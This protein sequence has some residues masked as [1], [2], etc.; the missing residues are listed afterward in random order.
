LPTPAGLDLSDPLP[1]G[2]PRL[3][4]A[5]SL[6]EILFD[7]ALHRIQQWLT[8]FHEDLLQV[9]QGGVRQFNRVLVIGQNDFRPQARGIIWD[10]RAFLASGGT[11]PM[12]PM[13]NYL[14]DGQI[15]W[16][17]FE[18]HLPADYPDQGLVS[19]M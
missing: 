4:E 13:V 11:S 14:P 17:F 2:L 6:R 16:Q 8:N 1:S 9:A 18:T 19:D 7:S 3:T 15:N 5:W 12:V 10:R